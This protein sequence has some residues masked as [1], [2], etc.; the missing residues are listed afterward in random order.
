MGLECFQQLVVNTAAFSLPCYDLTLDQNESSAVTEM[1]A[2]CCICHL[3][4][5]NNV[6]QF[7]SYCGLGY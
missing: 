7:P 5:A 6:A 4:P 3:L 1:V 2:Q